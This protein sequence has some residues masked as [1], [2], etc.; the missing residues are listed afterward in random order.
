[1]ETDANVSRNRWNAFCDRLSFRGTDNAFDDLHSRYNEPHRAYHNAHHIVDCLQQLDRSPQLVPDNDHLELS[2][3]FHDA[4]YDVRAADN[5]AASARLAVDFL[6]SRGATP[7]SIERVRSLILATMHT[8]T[9]DDIESQLIVDIDLSILGRP[10]AEY[11]RFECAIRN[12]YSWVPEATFRAKRSEILGEFLARR[13]LFLTEWF[14][15]QYEEQARRNLA[16]AIQQ[17]TRNYE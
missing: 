5:E 1:M 16:R 10:E 3:W 17:L 14:R 12:E 9:P 13:P 6:R 11:D 4:V 7:D 8:A 15:E 2:L